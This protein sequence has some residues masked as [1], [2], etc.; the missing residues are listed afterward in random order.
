MVNAHKSADDVKEAAKFTLNQAF[1]V[2]A[3]SVR[4]RQARTHRG[5]LCAPKLR[6]AVGIDARPVADGDLLITGEM[7][8]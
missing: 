7:S 2:Q 6:H 8:E 5:E 4:V 1:A 3:Y